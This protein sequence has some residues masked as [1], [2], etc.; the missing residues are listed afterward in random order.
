MIAI[1][2]TKVFHIFKARMQPLKNLYLLNIGVF[3]SC[4]LKLQKIKSN[5][6][7]TYEAS[8]S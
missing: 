2:K 5:P 4:D 7:F 1:E 3:F 6:N 8:H